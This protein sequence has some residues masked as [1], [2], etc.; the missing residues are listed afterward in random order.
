MVPG[1]YKPE[2]DEN[3]ISESRRVSGILPLLA[4]YIASVPGRNALLMGETRND[5]VGAP[6]FPGRRWALVHKQELT[7]E[8]TS[9]ERFGDPLITFSH[10]CG[11]VVDRDIKP[12]R[13]ELMIDAETK[14]EIY[15]VRTSH[16]MH[17]E[18]K[19]RR[20]MPEYKVGPPE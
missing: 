4:P 8:I 18:D 10:N 3:G 6:K 11:M 1:V 12:G 13:S 17:W 14:D 15:L 19:H 9:W 5:V 7:S 16:G 2:V 20:P